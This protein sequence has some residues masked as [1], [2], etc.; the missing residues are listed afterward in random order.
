VSARV[1]RRAAFGVLGVL[2][3]LVALN[4]PG[5]GSDPWPFRTPPISGHGLLGPLVRAADGRWDLGV[6]RTP[7]VLAGVLV[8]AIAI[9]GWRAESWRAWVLVAACTAVIVL[10]TVPATLLQ[11]GL[12]DGSAPWFH[13]NDSTYQIELAGKL[14]RHGHTPYGRNFEGSGLERFYTRD[15][16]V[17][18]PADHQ[19]VAL[20]H[21]AYFP[22][23]ALTAAAWSFVPSPF[24]DYRVLVLLATIGCFFAVLLF[25]APLPWRL[26]IGSAVAASPLLVRGSWFG[27]ADATAILALLLTFALFTRSQYVWAAVALAAAILLKQFALV[28]VP[29]FVL[30]LLAR[31]L[32]RPTLVRAAAAFAAVLAAGFLPFLIADAGALWTDTIAYGTGTYRILGYGLSALLLN[33]GVIDDR[34][35]AYPFALLALLVWLPVTA[36]LLWAVRRSGRDWEAAAG[37]AVSVFVLLFIA[38]VFQTSY[39]IWPLVGIAIAF[40]LAQRAD[41]SSSP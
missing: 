20:R 16:T 23:T 19:Q 17:P 13:V 7:A 14:V 11:V 36:W 31:S 10:V 12:R 3:A 8:A 1:D 34:Y 24:D 15:G 9:A 40:L 38:R 37:F 6:V 18:P 35:S 33:A 2:G 5:L 27:T 41:R 25:D 26:V 28:A 39:L 29:F 21:F 22:G 30:M 32:P 4:V